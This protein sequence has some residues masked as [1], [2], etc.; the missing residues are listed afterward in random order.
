M[1]KGYYEQVNI[2]CENVRKCQ[3]SEFEKVLNDSMPDFP[4]IDCIYILHESGIQL[5]ETVCNLS[6]ERRKR[7]ALFSPNKPGTDQSSKDYYMYIDENQTTYVTD[8]YISLASGIT[9]VTISK[10]IRTGM[11]QKLIVCIDFEFE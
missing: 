10:L 11:G 9:C 6:K 7:N 5:S 4:S 8:P 1:F 3:N 2:I